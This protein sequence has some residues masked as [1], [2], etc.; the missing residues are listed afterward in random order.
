[1]ICEIE[2][3]RTNPSIKILKQLANALGVSVT[4]LLEEEEN[5]GE[6]TKYNHIF[7][8]GKLSIAN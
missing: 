2:N 4:E 3:G 7:Y 8:D 6:V 5:K 1:M